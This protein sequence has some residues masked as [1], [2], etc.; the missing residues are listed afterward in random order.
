MKREHLIAERNLFE[1]CIQFLKQQV[2][3]CCI[4]NNDYYRHKKCKK[5]S[6]MKKPDE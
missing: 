2:E 1:I 6:R 5:T 4:H 3:H